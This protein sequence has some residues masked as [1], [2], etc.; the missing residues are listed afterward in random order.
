MRREI[1][2]F[3]TLI[4]LIGLATTEMVYI[5]RT[6]EGLNDKAEQVYSS[7]APDTE[8]NNKTEH[9]ALVDELNSRWEKTRENLLMI[10]PHIQVD[11]MTYR[12]VTLKENLRSGDYDM[13]MVTAA[14]I[15]KS[16]RLLLSH[17]RPS[18]RT[19]L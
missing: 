14:T 5:N 15:V 16:S 7:V 1:M 10:I 8:L 13:A 19:I 9:L 2:F 4:I 12:I 11:E 3:I 6:F 17:Y 18:F